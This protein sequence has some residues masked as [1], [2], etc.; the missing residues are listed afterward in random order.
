MKE[1]T[2]TAYVDLKLQGHKHIQIFTTDGGL[3]FL[4]RPLTFL[5]FE[6]VSELDDIAMG[7]EINDEVVKRATL[8]SEIDIPKWLE[9]A[10]AIEPDNYA[11][12]ILDF[13]IFKDPVAILQETLKARE[14]AQLIPSLIELYICNAYKA[15]TPKDVRNMN[16]YEQLDLMAK[17]ESVMGQPINMDGIVANEPTTDYPVPEGMDSTEDMSFLNKDS[18]DLPSFNGGY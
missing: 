8:W 18:A 16:M 3:E 14:E 4:Y 11:Q 10:K 12:A 1:N 7:V 17:S 2:I 15:I 6:A 9:N 13:S 5:E